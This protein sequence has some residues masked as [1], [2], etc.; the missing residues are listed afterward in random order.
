MGG[1]PRARLLST[2]ALLGRFGITG[3][4]STCSS[5]MLIARRGALAI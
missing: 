1:D 5:T 2:T 4:P 3:R